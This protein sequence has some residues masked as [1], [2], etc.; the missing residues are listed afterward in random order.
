MG[1]NPSLFQKGDDYPVEN[2]SW[3]DVQEFINKLNQKGEGV[4]RLPTEAEWE[5]SCRAGTDTAYYFGDDT[6][7]LDEYA[8]YNN[9][10][11]RQTHPVGQKKPNGWRLY[12]MHGN[13]WEWC[14]DYYASYPSSPVTDPVNEKGSGRVL[15]GGSWVNL[16][17]NCRSASRY[18][19]SPDNRY[20]DLG[21][22]LSRGLHL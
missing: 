16:A 7:H 19:N 13:V 14:Q 8:W 18:G 4:Y 17:G 10:S 3:N 21:F 1:E 20:N 22:R 12:D 11:D 9:N 15:R 6:G 2:V 5:Y